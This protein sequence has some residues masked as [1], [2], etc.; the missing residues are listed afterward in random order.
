MATARQDIEVRVVDKTQRA[1]GR[2]DKRLGG[3]N[4]RMLSLGKLAAVATTAIAAI[5]AA[6]LAKGFVNVAREMENLEVRFGFLFGSIEEGAKAF[7][8]LNK[9]AGEVPFS[10]EEIV[11]ASGSLAVIS[12][13]AKELGA[14]L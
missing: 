5:G 14:N 9:F 2:I 10:L 7:E 13:D 3:I 12:K 1:L 6:K 11:A 8:E 4:S